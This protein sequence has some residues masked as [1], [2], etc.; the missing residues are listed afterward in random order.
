MRPAVL[1]ADEPTGALDNRSSREILQLLREC[2][3]RAA[4]TVVM[5]THDPIAASFA[6]AVLFVDDGR[7]VDELTTPTVEQIAGRMTR[8]GD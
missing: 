7:I 5:V 1:F 8:L 4:L 6:D 3:E 2:V